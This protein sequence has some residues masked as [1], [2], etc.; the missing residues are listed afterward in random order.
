MKQIFVLFVFTTMCFQA[1][2]QTDIPIGDWRT[3]LNYSQ[4]RQIAITPDRVYCA[5]GHSVFYVDKDDKS[6]NKLTKKDGLSEISIS[7]INYDPVTQ[8]LIMG[9]VSGHMDMIRENQIYAINTIKNAALPVS[10]TINH[11]TFYNRYAYISTDFGIPVLDLNKQEIRETY[12]PGTDGNP[13]RING[14]A[15]LNDSI[16]IATEQGLMAGSLDPQ[17][18][19]LDFRN[20]KRYFPEHG[21]PQEDLNSIINVQNRIYTASNSSIYQYL[22]NRWEQLIID[23]NEEIVSLSAADQNLLI[24]TKTSIYTLSSSHD[25]SSITHPL[26]D[27]PQYVLHDEDG[28]YWIADLE[29]GLLKGK[30]GDFTSL[31]PS[32]PAENIIYKLL[33]I[34]NK[35]VAISRGRDENGSSLGKA[36]GFFVFENGQWV[37]YL[38]KV[39]PG[40]IEIPIIRDLVD[41][42]YNSVNNKTYFASLTD[43]ILEWQS[44]EFIT[45]NSSTPQTTL[46]S[47]AISAVEADQ[48]GSVW[49]LNY[50]QSPPLHTLSGTNTW[51]S[52]FVN[53]ATLATEIFIFDNGDKWLYAPNGSTGGIIVYN[54]EQNQNRVLTTNNSNGNLPSHSVNKIA[55][56]HSGS[57]WLATR[58]GVAY[59]SDPYRTLSEGSNAVYPVYEG[60]RLLSGENITSIAIDAGNRKWLSTNQGVWLFDETGEVLIH[61]FTTD[62]SPLLSNNIYDIVINHSNG[63]V[64]VATDQGLVSFRGS[65]TSPSPNHHQVKI[66]PNPVT[67]GFNGVVGIQG[68]VENAE[69]KITDISGKLIWQTISSGGTATWKVTDYNGRRAASGVYLVFSSDE[70]GSE[71]YV[72]KIAVIN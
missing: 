23:I 17:V 13:V 35:M 37:N 66:F 55:K 32:G 16:F 60:R 6:F 63:E 43:G 45:L 58:S 61:H 33:N 21:V 22:D 1:N 62:N 53:A 24:T 36:V 30:N 12:F 50:N 20:W 51:T 31:V 42:S 44:D 11:I 41:I 28:V 25:L 68:L 7:A 48:D 57:I 70:S 56:D 8:F 14:S 71:T 18:N 59:I 2:S 39:K 27:Q 3:H 47:A 65:A 4:A 40:T 67:P 29:N 10:K 19:L 38:P 64:F 9:S 52:Y 54:E 26:I 49:I 34:H 15:I 72:G 5:T 69:V 46:K